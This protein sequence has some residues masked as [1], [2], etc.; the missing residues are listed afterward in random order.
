MSIKIITRND[1]L[2][3]LISEDCNNTVAHRAAKQILQK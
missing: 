3:K 2:R 1:C